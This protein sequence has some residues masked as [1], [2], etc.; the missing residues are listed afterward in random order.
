MKQPHSE[1][2]LEWLCLVLLVVILGLQIAGL[3][4]LREREP[5]F[6]YIES[7]LGRIEARLNDER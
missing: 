4:L 7:A 2:G 6:E 1:R 3:T 5:R